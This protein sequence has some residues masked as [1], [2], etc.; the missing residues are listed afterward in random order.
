MYTVESDPSSDKYHFFRARGLVSPLIARVWE[1]RN[2]IELLTDERGEAGADLILRSA[3]R[4]LPYRKF[5][6]AFG[7]SE[8]I[9]AVRR[10]M[11][12]LWECPELKSLDH[13]L[14]ETAC[15][16]S[17]MRLGA[18][19]DLSEILSDHAGS[20]KTAFGSFCLIGDLT[21]RQATELV[22]GLGEPDANA[23][24]FDYNASKLADMLMSN[25]HVGAAF[26]WI[27]NGDLREKLILTSRREFPLGDESIACLD[28]LSAQEQARARA[29]GP[30]HFPSHPPG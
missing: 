6:V 15:S 2:E 14:F 28:L 24:F 25:P 30:Y 9:S 13:V 26:Y 17:K 23:F 16:E 19:V 29:R 7:Q 4:C 21:L 18:I 8:P 1:F 5:M 22:A 10:R 3:Q 11:G 27:P 12:A 20:D